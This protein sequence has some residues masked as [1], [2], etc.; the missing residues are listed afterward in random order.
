MQIDTQAANTAGGAAVLPLMGNH[1]R[2]ETHGS[3][4]RCTYLLI[5][6]AAASCAA[7]VHTYRYVLSTAL[8]L[9]NKK[10]VG[11]KHGMFGN[12]AFPGALR[13]C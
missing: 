7:A 8:G 1:Q 11:K 9:F 10:L 6:A 3:T 13:R 2:Q 5:A 12:G 4:N